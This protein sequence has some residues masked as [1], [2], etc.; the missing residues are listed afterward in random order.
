MPYYFGATP[1]APT[2]LD[3]HTKYKIHGALEFL[4]YLIERGKIDPN[5]FTDADIARCFQVPRQT[6]KQ[7]DSEG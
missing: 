6:V 2:Y 4:V 7:I 3:I 5:D 1:P